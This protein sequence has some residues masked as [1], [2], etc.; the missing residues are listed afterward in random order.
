MCGDIT[1]AGTHYGTV[2]PSEK[3]SLVSSATLSMISKKKQPTG[4][5]NVAAY[6]IRKHHWLSQER[7]L[8][9]RRAKIMA[10]VDKLN[11]DELGKIDCMLNGEMPEGLADKQSQIEESYVN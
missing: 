4:S 3:G 1:G 2:T 10:V 11:D 6:K 7:E 5:E 8:A 9:C